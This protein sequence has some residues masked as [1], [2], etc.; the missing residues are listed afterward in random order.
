MDRLYNSLEVGDRFAAEDVRDNINYKGSNWEFSGKIGRHWGFK[1]IGT[2]SRQHPG[3]KSY[4]TNN[5]TMFEKIEGMDILFKAGETPF[6]AEEAK[7]L[8]NYKGSA[9]SMA[10]KIYYDNR[11][12]KAGYKRKKYP[13]GKTYLI[14]AYRKKVNGRHYNNEEI[15]EGE[16]SEMEKLHGK[17][18]ISNKITADDAIE[19]I[20][21]NNS[22]LSIAMKITHDKG[23]K[24][25]RTRMKVY[26][27][28]RTC[29]V[30]VYMKIK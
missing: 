10:K 13:N 19:L 11:F 1:R 18:N 7:R 29:P 14:R 30:A 27:D 16:P 15:L 21:Y 5:V 8:I 28:G 22:A 23:F 3:G 20:G 2:E 6:T 4:G 26:D 25:I 24:K 17:L 12:E 9:R